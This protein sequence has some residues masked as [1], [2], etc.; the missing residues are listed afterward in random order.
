MK[1]VTNCRCRTNGIKCSLCIPC[2]DARVEGCVGHREEHLH[3][4]IKCVVVAHRNILGQESPM[5]R[6]CLRAWSILPVFG[7]HLLF[8]REVRAE[9]D[10]FFGLL[11]I[12]CGTVLC[13]TKR[14]EHR[15]EL[16][17]RAQRKWDDSVPLS[18]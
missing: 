12:S 8:I 14:G 18:P 9:L 7:D 16:I 4:L 13:W 6:G 5:S 3:I 2:H 1:E 15:T 11:P 10:Q 17:I